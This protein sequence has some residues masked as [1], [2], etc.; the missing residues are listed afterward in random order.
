MKKYLFML[1]ALCLMPANN[2]A[3][4]LNSLKDIIR[5]TDPSLIRTLNGQWDFYFINGAD[6]KEQACFYQPDYDISSW[7]RILVPGCWDALGY[8]EPKYAN[9]EEINGLYRK[10]FTVPK[11]WKDKHVF[12]SFDGVLRGYEIWVNGNYVGKWESSYNTCHFDVT[13]FLKKGENLLA[14]R[15]YTHYKGFDFDGND[16]WGQVGIN[17]NVSMF[18]IPDTHLKDFT[19]RTD[20]VSNESARINMMFDIASFTSSVSANTY[21]EGLIKR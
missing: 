18:A 3:Q 19:L 1:L 10:N 15:V 5:P 12:L 13:D 17:R 14:V 2:T 9:P 20:S 11:G 4:I 21:I 7:D 6:W 16:D 8:V